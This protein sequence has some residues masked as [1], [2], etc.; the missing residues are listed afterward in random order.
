MT[1]KPNDDPDD[2]YTYGEEPKFSRGLER[3][4][5][6]LNQAEQRQSQ[7]RESTQLVNESSSNQFRSWR[8]L[9]SICHNYCAAQETIII[10]QRV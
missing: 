5:N 1:K 7:K 2:I 10:Q 6:I 4:Y 8:I 3:M 9:I